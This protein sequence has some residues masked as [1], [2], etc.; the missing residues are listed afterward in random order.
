MSIGDARSALSHSRFMLKGFTRFPLTRISKVLGYM[1]PYW[2]LDT[3]VAFDADWVL[4]AFIQTNYIYLSLLKLRGCW[5]LSLR[6]IT[7]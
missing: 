3:P 6:Q 7:Q 5:L 4:V 2:T 1:S